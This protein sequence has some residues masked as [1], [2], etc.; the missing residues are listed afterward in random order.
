MQK[1]SRLADATHGRVALWGERFPMS[2]V[3]RQGR[4][5]LEDRTSLL[6]TVKAWNTGDVEDGY[7]M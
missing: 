7:P 2:Q 4:G 1:R 5:S 3:V 6:P